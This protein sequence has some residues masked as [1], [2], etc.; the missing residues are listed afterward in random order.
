MLQE[1]LKKLNTRFHC[2]LE[3]NMYIHNLE[4]YYA[5]LKTKDPR[6]AAEILYALAVINKSKGKLEDAKKYVIESIELF[7]SLN[8]Q[9]LEE[10]ASLYSIVNGVV[11]PDYIHEG[12]VRDRL[13]DLL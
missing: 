12:V 7:E 4:S 8:I 9:T 5:D 3:V 11:I 6:R 2:G 1:V 10:S 13:S